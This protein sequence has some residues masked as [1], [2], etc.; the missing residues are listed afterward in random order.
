MDEDTNRTTDLAP[1]NNSDE[2]LLTSIKERA[3]NSLLPLIDKLEDSPSRKFDICLAAVRATDN[4]K[5]LEK[6]LTFAEQIDD[7]SEKAQSLIDIANEATVRL[8]S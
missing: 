8:Q 5:L 1:S 7:L 3:F 2:T 6:A 4:P